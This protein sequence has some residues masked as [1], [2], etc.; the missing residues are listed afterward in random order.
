MTPK[1]ACLDYSAGRGGPLV[2]Y[3]WNEGEKTLT[4]DR[5]VSVNPADA[6]VPETE[7]SWNFLR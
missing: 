3:R 5:F 7:K 4:A 6:P 2:A 1:L